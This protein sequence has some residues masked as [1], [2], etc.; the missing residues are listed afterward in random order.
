MTPVGEVER[1]EGCWGAG[2]AV[3]SGDAARK[4]G[5]VTILTFVID[6]NLVRIRARINTVTPRLN[7]RP[8]ARQAPRYLHI[9]RR[10]HRSTRLTN[11]TN[12]NGYPCRARNQARI[13][14]FIEEKR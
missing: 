6:N 1:E 14:G 13:I 12:R 5:R 11:P 9:T 8:R 7:R 4:T 2:G 10:T 3:R